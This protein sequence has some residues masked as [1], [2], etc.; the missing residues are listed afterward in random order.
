MK[1]VGRDN[2][3]KNQATDNRE[4]NYKHNSVRIKVIKSTTLQMMWMSMMDDD[5]FVRDFFVSFIRDLNKME[6]LHS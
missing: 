6:L 3:V 5:E 4:V 2:I 1:R